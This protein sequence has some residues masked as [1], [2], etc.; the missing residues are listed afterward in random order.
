MAET[1]YEL[2][3]KIVVDATELKKGLQDAEGDV[4]SFGKTTSSSVQSAEKS[5]VSFVKK[6]GLITAAIT[7][8]AGGVIA[9]ANSFAKT[10]TE[11][12]EMSQKTGVSVEALSE[13]K[14]A[15]ELS[16]TSLSGLQIGFRSM[17]NTLEESKKGTGAANDA[18]RTLGLSIEQLDTLTPEQKFMTL[19]SAIASLRDPTQRAALAVD[20]F[21]RSGTELLPMLA[22]GAEG[23][24]KLRDKAKELGL[25]MSTET[26]KQ[27]DVLGDA[28]HTAG[29]AVKGFKDAA[30]SI[31]APDITNMSMGFSN[32]IGSATNW[33]KGYGWQVTQTASE[34]SKGIDSITESSY[35]ASA[36][37]TKLINEIEYSL[38]PAGGFG[39]TMEDIY[40][41]L[42]KNGATTEQLSNLYNVWGTD[43]QYV[44]I[45]LT[46][47]GLTAEQ[48]AAY[49]DKLGSSYIS[50][51]ESSR[52][53]QLQTME[54]NN[55]LAAASQS[56]KRQQAIDTSTRAGQ[57]LAQIQSYQQGLA[58]GGFLP[59]QID[60]VNKILQDLLR[61]YN[62]LTTTSPGT[63]Y[64]SPGSNEVTPNYFGWNL[65]G[66]A[67][68]GIVSGP[69]G[70]PQLAMVHGGEEVIPAG[71]R[72]GDTYIVNG[73]VLVQR[74]IGEISLK[75]GRNIKRKDYTTGL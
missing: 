16:G 52:L 13:L 44:N 5:I 36:E 15:A 31:L 58:S 24:E 34:V 37:F 20:I 54:T 46:Q 50:T 74:E 1:L 73:S 27:A 29:A 30:L 4:K 57:L 56:Q 62:A 10:G 70:Q 53:L 17:A 26:A 25:T 43:I 33:I 69:I 42:K 22:D 75:Y 6:A 40:T 32:F 9:L 11:L 14:Y 72:G 55:A 45:A 23:I 61:E 60:A 47:M 67:T 12:W 49:V 71:A 21:G 66:Y 51:A 18:L 41:I 3:A 68:G 59:E 64:S 8:Y 39:L 63:G 7:G 38:T 48:A 35:K 65:P 28:L 19:A 2:A